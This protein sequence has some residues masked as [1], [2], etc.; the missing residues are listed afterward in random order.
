MKFLVLVLS[1]IVLGSQKTFELGFNYPSNTDSTSIALNADKLYNVLFSDE[2]K[3]SFKAFSYALVG[4]QKLCAEGKLLNSNILTII[5]YTKTSKQ[6][7][8]WVLDLNTQTIIYN[9]LVAHGRNSGFEFPKKFSNIPNSK[10]SSPG[11]FITG[12]TYFGKHGYSLKIDGIEPG[13]NDKAR[14][15]AIVIHSADYATMDFVK[16]HGRLGRSYG[17]PVLPPAKN[18]LVI[19]SIKNKSC[20][21][22]YTGD[23]KYLLKSKLIQSK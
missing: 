20:L 17:C 6:R 19:D 1:F 22:I 2:N 11:F 14:D 4:Q 7:R 16:Q 15:R 9:T 12:E 3:P 10:M 8:L 18:K 13:I 21:F 23:E 5:D